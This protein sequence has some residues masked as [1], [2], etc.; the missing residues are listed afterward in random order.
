M[1]TAILQLRS[2][3]QMDFNGLKNQC[4]KSVMSLQNVSNYRTVKVPLSMGTLRLLLM[5]T[6]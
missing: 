3:A 4:E 6:D 2:L 5:D 1:V